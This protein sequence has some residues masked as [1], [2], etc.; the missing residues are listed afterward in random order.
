MRFASTTSLLACSPY[1]FATQISDP[2]RV[3]SETSSIQIYFQPL[4]RDTNSARQ[5][6]L[7]RQDS[8]R[9]FGCLKITSS[10]QLHIITTATY[11]SGT[12]TSTYYHMSHRIISRMHVDTLCMCHSRAMVKLV[13]FSCRQVASFQATNIAAACQT[14]GVR[15]RRQRSPEEGAV[16]SGLGVA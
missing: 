8:F 2:A 12:T 9:R 6:W 7:C 15:V 3:V 16:P 13:F 10:K 5:L 14:H 11:W 4:H 1:I